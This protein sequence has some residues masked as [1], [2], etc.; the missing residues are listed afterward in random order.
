M[1][2]IIWS[3]NKSESKI[4]EQEDKINTLSNKLEEH[5]LNKEYEESERI[6][7]IITIEKEII[8]EKNNMKAFL[9]D[10]S[11]KIEYK[12]EKIKKD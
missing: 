11:Q 2:T 3:M 12:D 10:I 1:K 9:N 5:I 4:E 8:N 6:H 7:Q